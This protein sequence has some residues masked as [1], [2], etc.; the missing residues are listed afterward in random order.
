M[1][2]GT[3]PASVKKIIDALQPYICAHTL[4]G[5]GGELGFSSVYPASIPCGVEP[6]FSMSG[7]FSSR[8]PTVFVIK[9][10][11]YD[12]RF[13]LFG[14]LMSQLSKCRSVFLRN[15]GSGLIVCW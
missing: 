4:A 13:M 14:V 8:F 7:A 10:T 15:D 3:E 9:V 6:L 11:V 5:A 1:A 2:P 12:H